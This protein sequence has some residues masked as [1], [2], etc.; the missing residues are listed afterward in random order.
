MDSTLIKEACGRPNP[1]FDEDTQAFVCTRCDYVLGVIEYEQD[2]KK[3][4]WWRHHKP[5]G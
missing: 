3:M 1:T 2:G 5:R 4:R